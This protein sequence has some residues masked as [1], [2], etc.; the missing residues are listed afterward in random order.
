MTAGMR[1]LHAIRSDEF[2]GVEQFVR[3]LAIEQA[4]VGHQVHVIGGDPALM[5]A[6]LNARGVGFTPATRTLEVSRAVRRLHRH[7]DV[8]NTHMTAADVGAVFGLSAVR[9]RPAIVATRHFAQPRGRVGRV[10]IDALVRQ[11]IDAE[12]SV[13]KAVAAAIGVDST[14]VHPGVEPRPQS[15]PAL[16]TRAV[17]I[18][19][20]L[21]PEKATSHGIRAFAESGLAQRGWFLNVAGEGAERESLEALAR[22]LG[23]GDAT[24]FIGFRTD[25]PSLMESAG[26]LLAPCPFEHFGLTV[27]EAM[28]SALPIVAADA[29]GHRE[30]LSGLD[31]RAL[32]TPGDV[33]A[34][35]GQMSSLAADE[36]GRAALGRAER[37]RQNQDFSLSAQANGTE[38]VYSAALARRRSAT[39]TFEAPE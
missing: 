26:V 8:V 37:E 29:A 16:R 13:S 1:I 11:R 34:A 30:M 27:V 36:P 9:S 24:R 23:I 38:K 32:F 10:P 25:L 39:Q 28:A 31:P 19:Q 33:S 4:S 21:Q 22:Q 18:A 35:A 15:S 2:S 3:R 17:L 5:R 7:V 20:R 14:V 6:P 12:I